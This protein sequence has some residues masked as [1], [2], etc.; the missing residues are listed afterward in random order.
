MNFLAHSYLSGSDHK[1]L[2]GNFIGDFVKGK[3]YKNYDDSIQKG[4]IL[5][6][7][8]DYYTDKH[9]VYLDSKSRLKSKY[10]H[11]SGVIVDMFYDHFLAANWT[12]YCDQDLLLYTQD[13]YKKIN[14]HIDI[15]P[16]GVKRLLSYMVPGNWVYAYG[17]LEGLNAA[18]TG[19]SHRTKFESKMEQATDDLKSNYAEFQSEFRLFFPEVIRFAESFDFVKMG[20]S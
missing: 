14:A 19:M 20:K 9:E 16:E 12:D 2:V 3:Q 10:R 15:V 7:E 5:H 8:I 6:R 17:G 1:I 4:I 18:L 13:I 11:Y